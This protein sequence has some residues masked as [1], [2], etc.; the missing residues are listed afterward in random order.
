MLRSLNISL[1]GARAG[2]AMIADK[3][4]NR[5][6]PGRASN[7]LLAREAQ[8]LVKKLGELKGTYVKVGQMLAMVGEFVLPVELTEALHTLESATAPLP[9]SEVEGILQTRL[10]SRYAELDVSPTPIGVASLAQVHRAT[11][12]S[13]GDQIVLKFLYPGVPESID[14]DFNAVARMLKLTRWI[15]ASN[16]FDDWMGQLREQLLHEVDYPREIAMTCRAAEELAG[17][18]RY[19]V[20]RIYHEFCCPDLIAMEYLEGVSV[21]D[22]SVTSLSLERRNRLARNML[23][24]F[25]KEVYEWHLL[26]SDPNFGNYRIAFDATNDQLI[27]LDFGSMLAVEGEFFC[28]LGDAIFAAQHQHKEPLIDA[29]KRL[30]CLHAG[31]SPTACDTFANFCVEIME[32][33]RE[34]NELPPQFLNAQGE[35][36]WSETKLMKRAALIAGRSVGNRDF[37]LPSEKF[38]LVTRKLIGVFTFISI[39]EA[40]F[41]GAPIL[42][43]YRD[44]MATRT[45]RMN[46][47]P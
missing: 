2:S 23:D 8:N 24:L 47:N 7:P 41:N 17:D 11:V 35:Y 36:R 16:G 29:L 40:E 21:N 13:S 5:L 19:R 10:G 28:A 32:P 26:Q 45:A 46:G 14:N 43:Q 27:L 3:A 15:K 37:D 44:S 4:L 34:A 22:A 9:W 6:L 30:G 39:L 20:P 1:A 38:A 18:S 25:F 42:E 12:R 31:S 33:M